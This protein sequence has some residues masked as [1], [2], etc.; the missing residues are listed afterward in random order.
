ME[1]MLK[2]IEK[3]LD[4]GL[5][6]LALQSA[7][8]LPDICGALQSDSGRATSNKYKK[9]FDKYAKEEGPIVLTGEECYHYRC[10][11]LHQLRSDHEKSRY[12][13]IK[14][15]LPNEQNIVAHDNRLGTF[16]NIDL[17]IF[18]RN[19]TAAVRKWEND[20]K[21]SPNF[22]RNY[23]KLMKTHQNGLAPYIFCEDIVA[24]F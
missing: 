1:F 9:W 24:I 18:C 22:I 7:L 5:Y 19:M 15:T 23:E 11:C 8:T 13:R 12:D 10:S 20:V 21:D 16:L 17:V 4:C 6:Y 2:E 3:A 14:F